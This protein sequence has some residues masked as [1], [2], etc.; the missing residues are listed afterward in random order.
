MKKQ[1]LALLLATVSC[2]SLAFGMTACGDDEKDPPAG[3][4]H[5]YAGGFTYANETKHWQECACGSVQTAVAHTID[6]NDDTKCTVCG[7]IPTDA[8]QSYMDLPVNTNPNFQ[9]YGYFHADGFGSQASYLEK[10]GALGNC[11]VAMINSA[12]TAESAVLKVAD[13]K[14]NGMKAVLTIHGL[15]D[16]VDEN[17]R[18]SGVHYN[19]DGTYRYEIVRS[20]LK[21]NYKEIFNEWKTALQEYIDD[22]TIL[23]FY[24][25][26]PYWHGVNEEDFRAITKYVREQ[27]PNTRFLHTMCMADIGAWIPTMV[28][29]SKYQ[30][31]SPSYNEYVT[32]VMYDGYG[33]W[34]DETRAKEMELLKATATNNQ[35][36][37]G[38]ATGFIDHTQKDP[39]A[40]EILKA[41][42]IGM[43]KE[44]IREPRYAGIMNFTFA[45]GDPN[46]SE[47]A[48]AIGTNQ[49]VDPSSE[50]YSEDIRQLNITIGKRIANEPLV[51]V[52]DLISS[53]DD[54]IELTKSN[55]NA[56]W[57]V[58]I[59]RDNKRTGIASLKVSATDK[60]GIPAI[61]FIHTTGKTWDLTDSHHVTLWAKSSSG[62]LA[63]YALILKDAAGNE[64][65]ATVAMGETWTKYSIQR[66]ELETAGVDLTAVYIEF[67]Y[68]GTDYTV[69]TS[70]NIDDVAIFNQE[71]EE[72]PEAAPD[73]QVNP[74]VNGFEN[75]AEVAL[76]GGDS[77]D[78]WCWPRALD[79]SFKRTGEASLIVTPHSTDGTWPNIV[80]MNGE[81]SVWDISSN[82]K[83]VS[84]WAYNKGTGT[85]SGFALRVTDGSTSYDIM[86][87]IPAGEWVEFKVDIGEL[88]VARPTLDLSN[89]T[90]KLSNIASGYENRSIFN[91]DDFLVEDG[92]PEVPAVALDP[93]KI[94]F[95]NDAE[96]GRAGGTGDD[97]WGWPRALDKTL[98]RTGEGSLKITPH[99]TDC[100]WPRAIFAPIEG[101]TWDLTK[102]SKVTIWGY[103]QGADAITGFALRVTD[104]TNHY[105]ASVSMTAGEWV[106]FE[107]DMEALKVAKPSMNLAAA[108]IFF[109]NMGATY[110]NRATFNLDDFEVTIPVN[111]NAIG[112]DAATDLDRIDADGD[113][114]VFWAPSFDSS[115]KRT[116]DGSLKITPHAEWGTWPSF[117]FCTTEGRVWDLTNASTIVIWVYNQGDAVIN[118]FGL[119]VTDGTN[120][121]DLVQ[122]IPA[123]EWVKFEISMATVLSAKPEFNLT[124]ANIR[125]GNM[126][127]DYANRC[128]FNI[129]D[130]EITLKE[131]GSGISNP[132]VNGFNNADSLAG[133]GYDG[134]NA[135][136]WPSSY[137]TTVKHE[138][139]GSLKVSPH[140]EWGTWPSLYF[141]N[142][143]SLVWDLTDATKV[144]VWAYN[145]GEGTISGFSLR[146]TDGTHNYDAM[147]DMPAGEWVKL[148]IDMT[149]L[150]ANQ[151]DM[152]LDNVNIKFGNVGATYD[153]RA[154]FNLDDFSVT[155]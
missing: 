120:S 59:D 144:T 137:D 77:A 30:P 82:I 123:G 103:N 130:F 24:M 22:G 136:F 145:A 42:L 88:I 23:M 114:F 67:A 117:F 53:F 28:D 6:P 54:T 20:P 84:L 83:S 17:G 2:T 71:S 155:R 13:A 140:A 85:I 106:K 26:E 149:A 112:F 101:E 121:Y 62:E 147:V 19:E 108:T 57:N 80:F 95:E 4:V 70:F 1:L 9:Y 58:A 66:A 34:D 64:V 61:Q 138:G 49:Y 12:W 18:A 113:N 143:E 7:V 127:S 131:A 90:I 44:G 141:K 150:L 33:Y 119:T 11:N 40:T 87:D 126:A 39:L 21:A 91:I 48:Y 31:V 36:I 5:D 98:K 146:V 15:T 132:D 75:T 99:P 27:C 89:V 110:T 100:T 8:T 129:D 152:D 38:C 128:A 60:A 79:R 116:G 52:K 109:G 43:Y 125:F 68:V 124:N 107:I 134:D 41:S 45:G 16:S 29:G 10:I 37:W 51:E 92:E 154:V 50:Y 105:D 72:F 14:A 63:D 96:V 3:H 78:M 94:G 93:Y 86:V 65:K 118:G 25:D 56:I 69:K 111:Q 76:A 97:L 104:G 139:D 35:W 102:A 148:E 74:K 32:D 81:S 135:V 115:V 133:I 151:P 55:P 153:N 73:I 142:G 122:N 47:F 46:A